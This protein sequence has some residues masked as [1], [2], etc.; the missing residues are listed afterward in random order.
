MADKGIAIVTYNR[1]SQIGQVIEAVLKTKPTDARVVVCDDGSTDDTSY[2]VSQFKGITYIRGANLG[3]G[4]NKNR[5][6]FTL[7]DCAFLCILEDDLVPTEKGWFELYENFFLT[8]GI[9]HL[10][11]VQDKEVPETL[12]E[13]S[14]DLQS[15]GIDP[16]YG[17][18][19][20]GDLTFITKKVV[21]KVGGFHPDFMGVGYAHVEWSNRV[22]KSGLI[23]H[24]N[25]WIDIKQARDKFIQL[26][27]TEGGRWLR[28]K[29]DVKKELKVNGAL[30]KKLRATNYLFHPL[31]MPL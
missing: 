13:F 14:T 3:V 31:I 20:R 25:K 10:C 2:I 19:V 4:A 7:Q 8:T 15:K 28:P 1:A 16:L 5:A 23:P 11:R 24:P 17:P 21:K 30:Y 18:N 27:D 9:H 26:G 12:L 29:Q 6:L 22:A